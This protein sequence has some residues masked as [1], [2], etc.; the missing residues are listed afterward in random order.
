VD[1]ERQEYEIEEQYTDAQVAA[2]GQF[3]A[4]YRS[5]GGGWENYQDLP[6]IHRPAPAIIA[7]FQRVFSQNDPLK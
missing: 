1:A 2:A 6:P 3:I 4:L 5:L 7:V